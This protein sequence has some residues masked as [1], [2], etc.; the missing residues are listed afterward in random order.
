MSDKKYDFSDF[1]ESTE[2]PK[3]EQSFDFSDFDEEAPAPVAE[4]PKNMGR[5]EAATLS[6][7]QGTGMGLTPI[8][9]G[10]VGAGMEL[11]EDAGDALG[12]TTGADLKK[13]G[14]EVEDNYK[15]LGGLL[16]AYYASRDAQKKA[17]STAHEEY[18]AQSIALNVAG[19]IPSTIATAGLGAKAGAAG[20]LL[21]S[22]RTANV[23]KS[24]TGAAKLGNSILTGA[25]EGAKAGAMVGFGEGEGKLLEGELGKTTEETLESATGG[26]LVGGALPVV[27]VG[28][29]KVGQGVKAVLPFV[30]GMGTSFR[31]GQMGMGLNEDDANKHI[32]G[33]S[34]DLLNAIR[35]KFKQAG[36]EKASVLDYAEEIGLRVDAGENFD[37]VMDEIVSRGASSVDDRA[38]KLKLYKAL[39]GLKDGP[40]DELQNKLD[41]AR[42]KSIDRMEQKGYELLDETDTQTN[43]QDFVSGSEAEKKI[44]TANQKFQKIN[45]GSEDLLTGAAGEKEVSKPITKI[46][47]QIGDELPID[48]RKYDLN[49]LSLKEVEEVLGEVN[50]YTGDLQGA[51]KTRS[52]AMARKL[53]GDIRGLSEEALDGAGKMSGNKN[54][55]NIF[56]AMRQLK[57]DD[58]V[59]TNNQFRKNNMVDT[60]QRMTRGSD[61]IKSDRFFEYL[62]NADPKTFGGYED[63]GKF[64]NDFSKVTKQNKALSSSN[65][66][67]MFGSAANKMNV[68]ANKAGK[69]TQA[70]KDFFAKGPEALEAMAQKLGMEGQSEAAKSYITPLMN[71]AKADERKRSAILYGL[72][73]QP[74]FREMYQSLGDYT[75]EGV[76]EMLPDAD[77]E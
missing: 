63:V 18:P 60:I 21:P 23:L 2:A 43:V 46:V 48:I 56:S 69:F 74:A 71:A 16:D 3:Q 24:G 64:L 65:T 12:L 38:E 14:F 6:F 22:A 53:A 34:E 67:G 26:A 75:I 5:A 54:L 35:R 36:M 31:G 61:D 19:A 62:K 37:G 1:E 32:K 70:G 20:V 33:Y 59:M 11:A 57:I 27:G 4:A 15:G 13:Q 10:A 72:Y 50:R 47:Q 68:V 51:P 77:K 39:K 58:N 76:G 66:S 30:D 52:E 28:I 7:G 55:H 44:G 42:A 9:S 41:T 45:E 40:Q 17:Q 25:R 8:L 29:K 49:N 73:Q